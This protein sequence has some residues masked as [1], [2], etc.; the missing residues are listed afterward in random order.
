MEALSI[1]TLDC[2]QQ[3]QRRLSLINSA[4]GSKPTTDDAAPA[5][6][7][8]IES[9]RLQAI[10]RETSLN[11]TLADIN[12][13]MKEWESNNGK[14]MRPV[15]AAPVILTKPQNR[16]KTVSSSPSSPPSTFPRPRTSSEASLAKAKHLNVH[17]R[18][19]LKLQALRDDPE[20]RLVLEQRAM[21]AQLHRMQSQAKMRST[22]DF[23]TENKMAY[24]HFVNFVNQSQEVEP[25]EREV[26]PAAVDDSPVEIEMER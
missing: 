21:A 26:G 20:K 16:Q 24:T 15:P 5:Q 23:V 4:W 19:Q 2:N 14:E 7:A 25:A 1:F 6:R 3:A 11:K 17:A 9:L 12:Q 18:V 8:S 13:L 10:R 22:R